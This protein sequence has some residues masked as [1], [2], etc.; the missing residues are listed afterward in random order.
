MNMIE[1]VKKAETVEEMRAEL[2]RL[3]HCDPLVRHVMQMA[4]YSGLSAE[5]RY[6]ILAYHAMADRNRFMQMGMDF[7]MVDNRIVLVKA[8]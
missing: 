8:E 6:T 4:D 7:T 2:F 5:D 3:S 1:Q